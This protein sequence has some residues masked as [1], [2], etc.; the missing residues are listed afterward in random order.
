MTN[1]SQ[2]ELQ[3]IAENGESPQ[4]QL[5]NVLVN[6]DIE[7][8]D[9][10]QR[11]LKLEHLLKTR[12][13]LV[14]EKIEEWNDLMDRSAYGATPDEPS[15]KWFTKGYKM[16]NPDGY[17]GFK[18]L[19][20]GASPAHGH[21]LRKFLG[22]NTSSKSKIDNDCFDYYNSGYGTFRVYCGSTNFGNPVWT[23]RYDYA[24]P[25]DAVG[26]STS[27]DSFKGLD[28]FVQEVTEQ[29]YGFYVRYMAKN[30]DLSIPPHKYSGDS[31][32]Q[33]MLKYKLNSNSDPREAGFS[34]NK[35]YIFNCFPFY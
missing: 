1:D 34:T 33:Y 7:T 6:G 29:G 4:E 23:R 25:G 30:V 8:E 14:Y 17:G 3:A 10:I 32:P 11:R 9:R 18:H 13:E 16:Y 20:T 31:T 2:A 19:G 27:Y 21:T 12:P 22:K 35:Y 26:K 28:L 5:I 15:K 24:D